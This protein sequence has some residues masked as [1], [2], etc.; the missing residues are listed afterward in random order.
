M[1][2][3]TNIV[4]PPTA[5]PTGDVSNEFIHLPKLPLSPYLY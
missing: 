2:P 1:K 5:I 3:K 4:T